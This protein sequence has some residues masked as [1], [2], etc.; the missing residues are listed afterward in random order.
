MCGNQSHAANLAWFLSHAC[1]VCV[2]AKTGLKY[3]IFTKH[4][5]TFFKTKTFELGSYLVCINMI[6]YQNFVISS[7]G[8]LKSAFAGILIYFIFSILCYLILLLLLIWRN[9]SNFYMT[10][11]RLHCTPKIKTTTW[12][13]SSLFFF[14]V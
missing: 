5:H 1:A 6:I 4:I 14:S 3:K 12:N 13:S 8:C 11:T 2:F 10:S 7:N 9:N